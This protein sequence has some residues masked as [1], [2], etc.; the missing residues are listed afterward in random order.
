LN[1]TLYNEIFSFTKLTKIKY[2][3]IQANFQHI[4]KAL[5]RRFI[6]LFKKHYGR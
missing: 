3:N 6:I 5:G 2:S 4:C 1:K